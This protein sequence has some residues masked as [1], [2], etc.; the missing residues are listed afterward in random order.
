MYFASWTTIIMP[1][2]YPG[3]AGQPYRPSNGSEGDIFQETFCYRCHNSPICPIPN[4]TRAV[5]VDHKDYPKEWKFDSD[6]KPTCTAFENVN[7]MTA[8]RNANAL[9][10][11]FEKLDDAQALARAIVDTTNSQ[12]TAFTIGPMVSKLRSICEEVL[13]CYSRES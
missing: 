11:L 10:V 8:K 9:K 2:C 13:V 4:M 1:I 7:N 5:D 3:N 12:N 6:G